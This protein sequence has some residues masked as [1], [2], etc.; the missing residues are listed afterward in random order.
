MKAIRFT[1]L[2]ALGAVLTILATGCHPEDLHRIPGTR[3]PY[4]QDVNPFP[5][6]PPTPPVTDTNI[7]TMTP[8]PPERNHTNW[9]ADATPLKEYAIHFGY[10]SSAV[11]AADKSKIA[12][13]AGY[14]KAN[15]AV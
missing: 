5:P 6:I 13:V 11:R 7:T 8:L 15:P 4:A 3:R 12:S 9:T 14:L 2:T 10:D 1:T